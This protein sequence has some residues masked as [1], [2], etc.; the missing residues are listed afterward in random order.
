M[1]NYPDKDQYLDEMLGLAGAAKKYRRVPKAMGKAL[2]EAGVTHKAMKTK[3][4]ADDGIAKLH[5]HVSKITDDPELHNKLMSTIMAHHASKAAT[6]NYEGEPTDEDWGH[7]I[8]PDED[9]M[10]STGE[11][12]YKE[13]PFGPEEAEENQDLEN[14]MGE[15]EWK[16]QPGYEEMDETGPAQVPDIV[17]YAITKKPGNFPPPIPHQTAT[18]KSLKAYEQKI[19]TLEGRLAH[20]EK[21]LAEVADLAARVVHAEKALGEVADYVLVLKQNKAFTPTQ[22]STAPETMIEDAALARQVKQSLGRYDPFWG[23]EVITGGKQ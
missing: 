7:P 10:S 12:E 13:D 19:A 16:A 8:E 11:A 9:D 2:S 21:A 18:G 1:S 15:V 4:V 5:D 6:P 14:R 20:A 22:A 17:N 3:G 23:G